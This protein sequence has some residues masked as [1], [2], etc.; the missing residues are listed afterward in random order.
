M[1]GMGGSWSLLST[2]AAVSL[3]IVSSAQAQAGRKWCAR[4]RVQDPLLEDA[5]HLGTSD[6][7]MWAGQRSEYEIP[8]VSPEA[9]TIVR[10][11]ATCRRAAIAYRPPSPVR[12]LRLAGLAGSRSSHRRQVPRR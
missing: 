8:R 1:A 5:R 4:P 3:F 7:P 6:K 11:E 10:D 9:I 12:R 2:L